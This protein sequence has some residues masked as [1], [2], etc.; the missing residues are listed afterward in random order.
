MVETLNITEIKRDNGWSPVR[1]TLGIGSF[2]INAFTADEAGGQVIPEH[3]EKT[4]G[5]E[6]AYIVVS[7]SASFTVDGDDVEAGVGSVVYVR[8]PESRRGAVA[9]VA[10]T[11]VMAVGG[12]PGEVYAPRAWEVNAEVFGM[13][14]RGEIDEAKQKLTAALD[15]YPNDTDALYYNLACA[16]ARL[17]KPDVA[18]EHLRRALEARPSFQDLAREDTDLDALRGDPRFDEILASTAASKTA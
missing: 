2:G 6:E 13:F 16:E 1:R 5:H 18:F 10:G 17:G 14:G 8:E 3:D 12:K 15:E 9:T 11:T 7:G 4:S